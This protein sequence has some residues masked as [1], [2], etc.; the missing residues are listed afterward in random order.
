MLPQESHRHFFFSWIKI[1]QPLCIHLSN[2]HNLV[3][4]VKSHEECFW[5]NHDKSDLVGTDKLKKSKLQQWW[6][7]QDRQW[8]YQTLMIVQDKEG[9]RSLFPIS[10]FPTLPL[11]LV[12]QVPSFPHNPI[13]SSLTKSH[14]CSITF[15]LII[16]FRSWR[17]YGW[18]VVFMGAMVSIF[19]ILSKRAFNIPVLGPY[20]QC[21][22]L[23]L[24]FTPFVLL[25]S[26]S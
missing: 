5:N 4:F 13:S 25:D 11:S 7:Q 17:Q 2:S 21:H 9:P 26:K 6:T 3:I 22:E 24:P 20:R 14:N 23:A 19:L 15:C 8:S 16:S 18:L 10:V 1:K 12:L